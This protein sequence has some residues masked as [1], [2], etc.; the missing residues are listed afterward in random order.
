MSDLSP[1]LAQ[2]GDSA[3]VLGGFLADTP[4]SL[5][6]LSE[7]TINGVPITLPKD[8]SQ[9]R[10]STMRREAEIA[11][12]RHPFGGP[13]REPHD[14]TCGSCAHCTA[15]EFNRTYHKCALM[16]A[17]WTKGPGSDLRKKW[18]ACERWQA[19]DPAT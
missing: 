19:K 12:G 14:E 6:G 13:L 8:L 17:S 15:V 5:F 16:R 4:G 9:Q 1:A 3:P 11:K 7:Y 2:P 18:P 10:A